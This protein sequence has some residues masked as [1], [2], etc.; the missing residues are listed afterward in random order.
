M[1]PVTPITSAAELIAACNRGGKFGNYWIKSGDQKRTVW[2]PVDKNGIVPS[3]AAD[4]YFS[5]HPTDKAKDQHSRTTG[6]AVCSI[7]HLFAEFDAKDF[8]GLDAALA[9][10]NA[11]PIKPSVIVCS[12]GGYHA[13][14]LF[15]CPVPLTDANRGIIQKV[16]AD[17]VAV[18]GGDKGAK[19]LARVLRVPG[20]LNHKYA[21]PRPVELVR[22][23]G[24][25]HEFDD[26]VRFIADARESV[27][28]AQ[29]IDPPPAAKAQQVPADVGADD[30]IAQFDARVK[31]A[32]ML[33]ESGYTV[34]GRGKFTRPG[35]SVS[36]GTSG[37]YDDARNT[38][39]TFSS[40]DPVAAFATEKNS[41]WMFGPFDLLKLKHSGD[42]KAALDEARTRIGMPPFAPKRGRGRPR[43][44]PAPQQ[45]QSQQAQAQQA[46]P[47]DAALVFSG[48]HDNGNALAFLAEH[49]S[50]YLYT[51]EMG[52]VRWTGTHWNSDGAQQEL[53]IEV[54]EVLKRRHAAALSAGD[55]PVARA[56]E[57]STRHARDAVTQLEALLYASISSFDTNKHL[58]NC[59]NGTV[60][61]RTGSVLPHDRG[62]RITY[63]VRY[64]FDPS[65]DTSEFV[66]WL[67]G[68][69][70]GGL[71]TV[72][73]LRHFL[74]Y[75]V[76]GETNLES[77]LYVYGAPRAG[78][79]T[80]IETIKNV[81]GPIMGSLS[82]TALTNKASA[83]N[84]ELASVRSARFVE[85]DEASN[86]YAVDEAKLKALTGNST[87][88]CAQKFKNP[89]SYT[90]QFKLIAISNDKLRASAT[91]AGLWR[92]VKVIEFV[93]SYIGQEDVMLKERMARPEMAKAVLAW[94]ISGAVDY[95]KLRAAG[96][97]IPE[98]VSVTAATGEH[99]AACDLVGLW[100][101]EC[102]ARVPGAWT[103]N[104]ELYQSYG[105]WCHDN[106]AQ[107]MALVKFGEQV[108]G[109]GFTQ[110]KRN[111]KRGYEGARLK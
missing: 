64:A 87:V 45:A 86:I 94:L 102:V 50:N 91:D 46:D 73:Y 75:A 29:V 65:A 39:Y 25:W 8:N 19:D 52:W 58:L 38:A 47:D 69:L 7:A 15:S 16:Q 62:N 60:D 9:H 44:N 110:S 71:D 93:N 13:Y 88:T 51:G 37:T 30:V 99:R 96:H 95:Y 5:V 108:R 89:F 31:I 111:G 76:T 56:S 40:N 83:Q 43:K 105:L 67:S 27:D 36:D 34:D 107:P 32:D 80:L 26:L 84:F 66:R 81:I 22:G 97:S 42:M 33:V 24:P 59:A 17:W 74:G 104:A 109:A 1:N 72:E 55:N 63:C 70:R 82:F 4:V 103:T 18:V 6:D 92:R 85:I 49:G 14:W 68:S 77:M 48:T 90:P 10:V 57:P 53:F 21:P 61:L 98:P 101:D 28:D 106:G 3:D 23:D 12:G 54:I 41:G 78:K 20:T 2:H 79:G 100:I 11:L 35:K